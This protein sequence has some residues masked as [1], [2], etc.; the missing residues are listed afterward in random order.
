MTAE[1]ELANIKE[2]NKPFL[3]F[4]RRSKYNLNK[5]KDVIKL[6][7]K[8]ILKKLRQ[9]NN[10]TQEELAEMLMISRQAISRWETGET[11]PNI[12]TLKVISNTFD[13]S[14]NTLLGS[15]RNLVCQVCGMPLEEKEYISKE[16]NGNDN[17]EYCKWCYV[18]GEHQYDESN[19]EELIEI[20][21]ENMI[22]HYPDYEE[23]HL[24][25]M[26]KENIPKLKYWQELSHQ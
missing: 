5:R 13:I 22:N 3:L 24:R 10:L 2:S 1:T 23:S 11:Q 26:L 4:C 14:I 12:D 8:E 17:D 15:P 9:D 6:E 25:E 20:C 21:V 7:M 18:D 16:K 19:F